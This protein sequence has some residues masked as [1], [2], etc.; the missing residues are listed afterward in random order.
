MRKLIPAVLIAMF[1]VLPLS[2]GNKKNKFYMTKVP[3]QGVELARVA[4]IVAEQPC[5]NWAWAAAMETILRRQNV[6]F[7]QRYWI[8][9]LNGGLACLPSAG[10]FESLKHKIDGEYVTADHR[11]VRIE[12]NYRESLPETSDALISPMV[13]GRPYV[14]WW[15]GVPYLVKGA[16]WDEFIYQTGQKLVEIKTLKLVNTLERGEKRDVIFDRTADDTNDLSATFD[17]VVTELDFDPWKAP[18]NP[19][20]EPVFNPAIDK[21]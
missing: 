16:T 14:I 11:H 20:T 9:K 17:A 21:K 1:L 15:K 2:A 19:A 8:M 7:D 5:G 4:E 13:H 18:H 3:D 10:T 12:I 6:D